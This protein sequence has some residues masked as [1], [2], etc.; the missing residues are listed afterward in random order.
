MKIT[1]AIATRDGDLAYQTMYDH[2]L[3]VQ[4]DILD[5]AFPESASGQIIATE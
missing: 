5:S 1:N 2:L 3:D 4:R